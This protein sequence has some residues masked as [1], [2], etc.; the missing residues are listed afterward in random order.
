MTS[1]IPPATG[2]L[3]ARAEEIR[4]KIRALA[5]TASTPDGA[6]TVTVDASGALRDIEFGHAAER[7]PRQALAAAV[8]ATARFAHNRA[9]EQ[10][11]AVLAA[12]AGEDS[13]A[14]RFTRQPEPPPPPLTPPPA[15]PGQPG[16][17]GQPALP[18]WQAAAR[19]GP[20]V[21]RA[22]VLDA[23][24]RGAHGSSHDSGIHDEGGYDDGPILR[25]RR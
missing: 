8:L 15:Q 14:V 12:L 5:G 13:A 16:Q 18:A 19:S 7:M 3:V 9:T 20:P 6:V 10:L 25:R 1:P 24:T 17:P 23:A 21:R 22:P 11:P 4:A 2:D